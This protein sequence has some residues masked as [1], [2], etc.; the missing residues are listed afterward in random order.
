MPTRGLPDY[1][2]GTVTVTNNSRTVTGSGTGWTTTLN[3]VTETTI[4]AGDM[5]IVS[6]GRPIM[7]ESVES[8]TS[9]TLTEVWPN[10]TAAGTATLRAGGESNAAKS[11]AP[12]SGVRVGR[13]GRAVKRDVATQRTDGKQREQ[14]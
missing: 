4:G 1:T 2:T 8:A 14:Q 11:S 12:E 7:V 13:Q 10:T 9:L 3:G 5:L 6:T